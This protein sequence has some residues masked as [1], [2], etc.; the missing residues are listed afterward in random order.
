MPINR[1]NRFF[2]PIDWPQISDSIR[3]KRARG[4]CER[5]GRKHLSRIRILPDG[6][7]LDTVAGDTWRDRYGHPS[8]WPDM[9]EISKSKFSRVVL[10][11]C[12]KD[13]NLSNNHPRNLAALCQWC[14]L[15]TDRDWN[16]HQM[17]ITVQMRRS[18]GDLFTGPYV[19]W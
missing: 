5:C 1:Q 11:C 16:R 2:Y 7:W 12:H 15:D 19:R 18:L 6:R 4:V 3:F 17:K 10:A 14:H 8:I 13:G 9:L